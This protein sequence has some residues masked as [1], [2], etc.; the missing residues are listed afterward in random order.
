MILSATELPQASLLD[1]GDRMRVLMMDK[2]TAV[3]VILSAER[4][5]TSTMLYHPDL[6]MQISFSG[7]RRRWT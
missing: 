4:Q 2:P 6:S 1:E 5:A 7:T 3:V